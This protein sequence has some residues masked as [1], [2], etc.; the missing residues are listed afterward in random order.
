MTWLFSLAL[1]FWL[2]WFRVT[3][4]PTGLPSTSVSSPYELPPRPRLA[5]GPGVC[6]TG[7]TVSDWAGCRRGRLRRYSGLGDVTQRD[8][9]AC[10]ARLSRPFACL[11]YC[12]MLQPDGSIMPEVSVDEVPVTA[13]AVHAY[14]L[15]LACFNQQFPDEESQAQAMHEPVL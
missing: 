14:W 13:G 11:G 5:I 6:N 2:R 8:R 9:G 7:T 4:A 1:V 12:S 10:D 15:Q 3:F